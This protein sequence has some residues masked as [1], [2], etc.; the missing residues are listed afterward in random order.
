MSPRR[1]DSWSSNAT[2]SIA[3]DGGDRFGR[4][5]R[6]T[7]NKCK[8]RHYSHR[9]FAEGID[10]NANPRWPATTRR[11][12]R[13]M[14]DRR[15]RRAPEACEQQDRPGGPC[16]N[17]ET[18]EIGGSRRDQARALRREAVERADA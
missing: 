3:P 6:G 4:P 1:E 5:Q 13:R 12:T 2:D 18:S 16:E 9:R 8:L 7:R 14:P 11:I 17:N 15:I 10:E